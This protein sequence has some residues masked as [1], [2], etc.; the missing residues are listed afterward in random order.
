MRTAL[1]RVATI[2]LGVILMAGCSDAHK[3]LL[4]PQARPE[5]TIVINRC[6]DAVLCT[7]QTGWIDVSA[8]AG[9][10]CAV[11]SLPLLL[12]VQ[13]T[14]SNLSCWGS[15]YSGML[16][17]GSTTETC[18]GTYMASGQMVPCSTTPKP[19]AGA[20]A[21]NSVS[22]GVSHVCAVERST[23]LVFCWGYNGNGQLGLGFPS[24]QYFTTPTSAVSGF[25][26]S[27]VSAGNGET[28]GLT[29]GQDIVC[30]GGSFGVN[31]AI[32]SG[33]AT[34]FKAVSLLG[35]SSNSTFCGLTTAG[36]SCT[37]SSTVF[38]MI[39]Q[40]TTA[41]HTCQISGG[42]VQCWGDNGAGQLGIASSMQKSASMSQPVVVP[43]SFSFV[44]TGELHTCAISGSD[45]FCWGDDNAGEL[46]D[47]T[48]S[49]KA[50][51]TKVLSPFGTTLSFTKISAGAEH[52]CAIANNQ[53]WC[54]G[55]NESGQLGI[56]TT[57]IT[58]TYPTWAPVIGTSWP[59][60]ASGT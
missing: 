59:V 40:A 18:P 46:G 19:V 29:T 34:K 35:A 49:T 2:A 45:A 20:R 9:V 47:Q 36:T 48:Q 15:N 7:A 52:T 4:A 56:G 1:V 41:H 22:V 32:A 8:G 3:D 28:C 26:F 50:V 54:W 6:S 10:T 55:R 23:N 14:T 42:T 44:S 17:V 58:L 33:G 60:H 27:S 51:P 5:A 53:I 25:T 39:G 31:P 37:N 57:S 38:D 43:G 21:F 11:H 24:V 30:W 13:L 16:G 12:T